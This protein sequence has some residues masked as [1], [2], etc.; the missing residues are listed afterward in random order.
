MAIA[1]DA[2]AR[3][4]APDSPLLAEGVGLVVA[5]F[6]GQP[7]GALADLTSARDI[8]LR[9][10]HRKG[11][12][13]WVD[14]HVLP[15]WHRHQQRVTETGETLG[16][17][18]PLDAQQKLVEILVALEA[19]RPDWLR[20]AIDP[21]L[22]KELF[23]P[24]LQRT[25]LSFARRL[26]L[27]GLGGTAG[28][29]A[30]KLKK[31]VGEHA[32]KLADAGRRAMGGLG[33]QLDERIQ[34]VAREFAEGAQRELREATEERLAS[35]EGRRIVS[36]LRRRAFDHILGIE[37][38]EIMAAAAPLPLEE[39]AALAGPIAEHNARRSFGRA[40]LEAEV[41]AFFEREGQ[42]PLRQ[43]LRELDV[44][45]PV[46]AA[47]ERNGVRFAR[48]LLDAEGIE[49]WLDRVLAP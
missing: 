30:D 25:L 20:D 41:A 13:W 14:G 24:V 27:A 46:I 22:V 37:V 32:E 19:P 9:A 26:P 16:D 47:L 49:G 40:A 33:A 2:L 4:R 5:H 42:K 1:H 18:L 31:R 21:D 45:A 36:E 34:T 3:L 29:F 10:A 8:V 12:E 15:S 11:T 7:L 28:G 17:L 39:L 6:L 23:A 35:D 44:E 48:G 38:A 43:V